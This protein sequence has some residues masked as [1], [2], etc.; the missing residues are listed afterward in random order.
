[1]YEVFMPGGKSC[2]FHA[3]DYDGVGIGAYALRQ[4]TADFV[5]DQPKYANENV[6]L[7]DWVR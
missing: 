2:I 3:L 6:P 7:E 1:V 5:S 4:S